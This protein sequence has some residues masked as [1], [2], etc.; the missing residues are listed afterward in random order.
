MFTKDVY[1]YYNTGKR[2]PESSVPLHLRRA[3]LTRTGIDANTSICSGM[4][5]A[6]Y[7]TT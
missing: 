3:R 5:K 2:I 1:D 6:R 4:L 7:Q